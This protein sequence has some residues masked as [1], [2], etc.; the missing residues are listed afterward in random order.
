M[1]RPI[2]ENQQSKLKAILQDK[3]YQN[4]SIPSD[5]K[6]EGKLFYKE[7]IEEKKSEAANSLCLKL[8]DLNAWLNQ[9]GPIDERSLIHFLLL[10]ISWKL[11]PF[12]REIIFISP[13]VLDQQKK[14]F[15]TTAGWIKIFH[16]QVNFHGIAFEYGPDTETGL[17]K[18][19]SCN[20]Y[21]SDIPM[22][23]STREYYSEAYK[24]NP[25]SQEN[26]IRYL[27]ARALSHCARLAFGIH[28][29]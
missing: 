19:I 14:G 11:N 16:N 2:I 12:L 25:V 9:E 5:L 15:I 1:N 4:K 28:V 23:I 10:I 27:Q 13:T 29:N 8:A 6:N 24:L 7:L 21:R 17:P 3:K 26:P 18:W 22:A 20:I